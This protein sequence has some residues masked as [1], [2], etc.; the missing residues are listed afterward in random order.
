MEID[1]FWMQ[2]ALQEAVKAFE[3]DEVPIGAIIVRGGKVIARAHNQVEQLQDVTAHA[4]LLAITAASN[5][6]N[7][8]YL[9]DCTIY[10]TLEPCPMCAYALNLAQV[11]RVVFAA[12]DHQ[13]GYR[14]F[15]PKLIH[16]SIEV[17]EGVLKEESQKLIKE[18]FQLK[19]LI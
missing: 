9:W 15:N 12:P 10:I 19:R 7:Q 18:F 14:S 2:Q 13:K 6:L 8:K 1:K 3:E 11:S 17:H 16:E 4:E 5:A